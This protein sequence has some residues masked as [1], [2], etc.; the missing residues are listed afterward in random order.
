MAT[1][2]SAT[3]KTSAVDALLNT[4][5]G[6]KPTSP[7]RSKG[8]DLPIGHINVFMLDALVFSRGIWPESTSDTPLLAEINEIALNDPDSVVEL[9]HKLFNVEEGGP[10]RVEV[11]MNQ[12]KSAASLTDLIAALG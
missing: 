4:A 5:V 8:K 2:K 10:V 3:S 7:R 6:T 12:A 1:R 11:K 9:F